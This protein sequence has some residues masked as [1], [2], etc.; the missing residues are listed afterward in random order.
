MPQAE[1][2]AAVA[3]V[4]DT[5]NRGFSVP[6]IVIRK[7]L[8]PL[9]LE[10]ALRERSPDIARENLLN[11]LSERMY[12]IIL[13]ECCS[14]LVQLR[15]ELPKFLPAAL[16]ELL[17]RTRSI[18]QTLA[19]ALEAL[20]E[21]NRFRDNEYDGLYR[22]A[23]VNALDWVELLGLGPTRAAR[24][25]ALSVAY[26]SLLAAIQRPEAAMEAGGVEEQ[27]SLRVERLIARH[28]RIVISG[29]AGSGKTT[30]LQWLAVRSAT[31]TFV[32]PL[33]ELNSTVPI[34]I[35]LRRYANAPLPT[36]DGFTDEVANSLQEL[37]PRAW[38]TKALSSGNALVLIDGVDELPRSQRT[39]AAR[40][41]DGIVDAFP[42]ARYVVTSRPAALSHWNV[43][44]GFATAGLAPMSLPD[45]DAFV[46]HWHRAAAHDI[47][48]GADEESLGRLATRLR[49]SI[50]AQ[51]PVRRLATNPLMCA[52]ICTL[53]R[54]GNALLPA[55]RIDL[56][57]TALDLLLD[58][59]DA[60]RQVTSSAVEITRA[61]KLLLLTDL[62]WWLVLNGYADGPRE[63]VRDRIALLLPRLNT[64]LKS[65]SMLDHL[66]ERTGLL[67][68][69]TVGR[70]DFVHRT[71]LEF[72]AAIYAVS[73]N[74]IG[75][76]ARNALD[77][78]FQEVTVLAAGVA[79]SRQRD[80]LV[81]LLLNT[82]GNDS[83]Q[84]A[85]LLLAAMC[86]AVA[87][88]ID[89]SIRAEIEARLEATPRP[90]SLRDAEMLALAGDVGV[91]ALR[92]ADSLTVRQAQASVRALGRTGTP[93]A[94]SQLA[95]YGRD[96]RPPVVRELVNQWDSFDRD[97][98]AR[99]V[100][101][102][103]PLDRGRLR[104]GRSHN[105]Q[106][107]RWLSQLAQLELE[108]PT[109]Y[110]LGRLSPV[111]SLVIDEPPDLYDLHP[112][113]ELT[114]LRE[115]S[116]VS[117]THLRSLRGIAA[118]ELEFLSIA[119]ASAL[120][121]IDSLADGARSLRCVRLADVPFDDIT[122]LVAHHS[123][124]TLE[125]ERT[126]VESLAPILALPKLQ[127][128]S[129][130]S[131]LTGLEFADVAELPALENLRITNFNGVLR[132]PRFGSED[133]PLSSLVLDSCQFGAVRALGNLGAVRR[134]VL[135]N[136]RT[137][138]LRG[139]EQVTGPALVSLEVDGG[140]LT[141][142]EEVPGPLR[143]LVLKRLHLVELTALDRAHDLRTLELRGLPV[144]RL[145]PVRRCSG[146]QDLCLDDLPNLSDREVSRTLEALPHLTRVRTSQF[147]RVVLRTR[148]DVSIV[149][150]SSDPERSA[151]L[152][153]RGTAL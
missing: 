95:P 12:G 115:L 6:E 43:P 110:Q 83:A 74:H 53:H 49:T 120:R 8:D 7:D 50:R 84:E 68:E 59:R 87:P 136:A 119:H 141:R 76:L 147:A 142:L 67:R 36:P 93:R 113:R 65:E 41:L 100:M 86:T 19:E 106:F 17:A 33:H 114:G 107:L 9:K 54:Q 46:N 108:Q 42:T 13:R 60:A 102:D 72:L 144:E 149:D 63:L 117:P 127:S 57:S 44:D 134:L 139:I 103:S 89:P 152:K 153:L 133:R 29:A 10:A 128:L 31:R 66:V 27:E 92:F 69:P 121:S 80:E 30:I 81:R 5:I 77:P 73:Q 137:P 130:A 125:L 24:R 40:W 78:K 150:A 148:P 22:R 23:M 37:R 140:F 96:Q 105:L 91:S 85:G 123:L 1:I 109:A 97:E 145:E 35:R 28:R 62:A 18:E 11:E 151:P 2:G 70:L 64:T 111:R 99:V 101:R 38:V 71:F 132:L 15:P 104:V 82:T 32:T 135:R 52:V 55:N 56:Y 21:A 79:D 14:Y 118:L 26:I 4:A 51:D 131:E 75:I 90:T 146:I 47:A 25:Y 61:Q 126:L 88:D 138:S 20:P 112:L 122:P 3:T 34:F 45:V 98:F 94:L 48:Q 129:V 39:E 143:E 16:A 124:R 116:L 58:H